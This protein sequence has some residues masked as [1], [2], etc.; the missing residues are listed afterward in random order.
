[1]EMG[2]FQDTGMASQWSHDS[3]VQP[4]GTCASDPNECCA[5]LYLM[6]NAEGPLFS[7]TEQTGNKNHNVCPLAPFFQIKIHVLWLPVHYWPCLSG[8][9]RYRCWKHME[10]SNTA[11]KRSGNHLWVWFGLSVSCG[12][13]AVCRHMYRWSR[14]LPGDNP[15]LLPMPVRL[16]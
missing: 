7:N 13:W 1:M 8:S 14:C 11:G 10:L 4:V 16:K 6:A 3:D 2:G 9:T 12:C 5:Y 15:C